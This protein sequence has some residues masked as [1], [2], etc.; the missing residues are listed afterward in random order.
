[1]KSYCIKI[2]DE[3]IIAYLLNKIEET[4]LEG[5]YYCSKE[6]KLYQNVILHYTGNEIQKFEN[7]VTDI[8]TSTIIEF[9]EEKIIKR[10]INSN[11]FYFDEYERKIILENCK[12]ILKT[13][14]KEKQ[15][16]LF[17]EIKKYIQEK[18][19]IVLEGVINFR[20]PRYKK[21]L[22]EIVDMA[23]NQYIIEKEYSE[24]ISLLKNYVN[25][26][27]SEI[28]SLHLIYSNGESILLDDD[29]NMISVS[30]NIFNAKYLSDISFSSNDL[31]L[32]TLLNLLPA[33]LDI[34]IIDV[35]DEFIETLKR[36]FDDRVSI[37]KECNIC[38][39]YRLIHHAK[40]LN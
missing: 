39:T 28:E 15:E 10:M 8:I 26:T 32:N 40:I 2:N 14:Q 9:F 31:A 5:I 25:N 18:N 34:H 22:D 35:E 27:P 6:F 19:K 13:E 29:K 17:N 11:Y 12:G 21:I 16:I 24:F 3:E 30:D 23:V 7:I 20:I 37:C 33:K 4:D 1:M 36:I 38:K